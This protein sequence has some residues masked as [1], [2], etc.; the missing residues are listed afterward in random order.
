MNPH[1]EGR[2]VRYIMT[3]HIAQIVQ[4]DG[5]SRL[6]VDGRPFLV[7]GLQWDCDSCFSKEE[8]N[9]LFPHAAALGANTAVLPVY[10]REVEP[11][12]GSYDFQMVDERLL[13]ARTHQLR[14]VLLWFATWKNACAFY[15][16]DY[17]RADPA[18][19]PLAVDRAGQPTVSLCP[20]GETTWLRDR[21]AL[22]A[23]MAHLRDVD[24]AHTV[25][26][27]QVE[28][29]P[30]ILRSDRCHCAVCNARFTSEGWE[31]RW[32]AHAAEAFSAASIAE[33]ID[34]LAAEA[35]AIYPLL[36]KCSAAT[37]RWR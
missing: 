28:N 9:P 24:T 29:E 7:L 11:T 1:A 25:I 21:A 22:T 5:Q 19:Y 6:L 26:M 14:V 18:T 17:I 31:T 27:L 8:M 37:R 15:A 10:W 13:Q 2:K 35:K 4:V 36:C 3:G 20:S 32:G 33:Y 23:L 34:R 16:P 30:G 12:A